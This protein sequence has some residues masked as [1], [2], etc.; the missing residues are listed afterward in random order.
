MAD[1][2]LPEEILKLSRQLVMGEIILFNVV[3]PVIFDFQSKFNPVY[4][5]YLKQLKFDLKYPELED[6]PFLPI[7]F[8]KNFRITSCDWQEQTVFRSSSTTGKGRSSHYIRDLQIYKT[9]SLKI[10]EKYFG[11]IS[12]LRIMALLPGYLE[13]EDSSLVYMV[14]YLMGCTAVDQRYFFLDRYHD[15][16]EVVQG[17][18]DEHIILFGVPYAFIR[19]FRELGYQF[20]PNVT[21]I[22]TGGMK[23]KEAEMTKAELHLFLEESFRPKSI[24]SEYGMTELLSQCYSKGEGKFEVSDTMYMIVKEL[25]DPFSIQKRGKPGV[26]NVF[27]M[28]NV[29]TCSFIETEDMAILHENGEFEILGRV[30]NREIRGCNLLAG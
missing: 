27:D 30:D 15:L 13:R 16:M 21:M 17:N 20:W 12:H 11:P 23:G 19:C 2:I 14:N 8:F 6:I 22:E 5:S 7:T 25:N 28:A 3:Y 24:Y 1:N 10:F 26:L 4:R 29:H 18:L 9:V